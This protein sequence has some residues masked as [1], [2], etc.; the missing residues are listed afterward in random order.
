MYKS[1]AIALEQDVR[2]DVGL[3]VTVETGFKRTALSSFVMVSY[4]FL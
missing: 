2:G 1:S 4:T 3:V